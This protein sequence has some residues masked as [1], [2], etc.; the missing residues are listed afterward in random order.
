MHWLLP[1]HVRRYHGRYRSSGRLGQGRFKAFP[2]E[3]DEHLVT[4]L[5]YI[6]RNPLRAGLVSRAEDW[7]WSS[8]RWWGAATAVPFLDPGPVP[9]GSD[10]AGHVNTPLH[11][12]D[13]PRIR[14]SVDR[15]APYDSE[16]WTAATAA[17][18]GRRFTLRPRGRP[19]KGGVAP[20]AST[21][22]PSLFPEET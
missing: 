5:R 8:L 17:A 20:P 22:A 18:L 1:T 2:I 3:Q 6:E 15:G 4:V 12:S 21:D 7:P 11:E 10:W 16:A 13:L 14:Y 19:P 9:R